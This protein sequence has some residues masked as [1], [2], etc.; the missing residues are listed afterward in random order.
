MVF[1]RS[2]KILG[3]SLAYQ[4]QAGSQEDEEDPLDAFMKEINVQAKS[5][6][7]QP[8]EEQ[9]EITFQKGETLGTLQKNPVSHQPEVCMAD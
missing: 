8:A 5:Q 2:S 7:V 1:L 6:G 9:N 4:V 3:G